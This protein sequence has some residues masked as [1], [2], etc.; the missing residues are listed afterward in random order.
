MPQLNQT[1]GNGISVVD[2]TQKETICPVFDKSM[3]I[4]LQGAKITADT[5]FLLLREVD[6]RFRLL[7]RAASRIE[8]PSI[9]PL[10]FVHFLS[11]RDL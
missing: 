11:S 9:V 5:G 8:D 2:E 7:E 10:I 4:D 1:E 3:S 6:G